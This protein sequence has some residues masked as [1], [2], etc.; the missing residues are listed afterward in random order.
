MAILIGHASLDEN[1]QIKKG[2]AGDQT[3]GEVCTRGWYDK[4]WGHLLRCKDSEIAERMAQAC[5]AACRN[6]N[7]GYDQGQRN[8]L[9]T[10][11]LKVGYD[12]S[13][14]KTPCECDCSSLMCICAIAAGIPASYFYINGNMRTTSS[15]KNAFVRTGLFDV[16]TDPNYLTKD[17]LLKRGDILTRPGSHTVMVLGNGS[18]VAPAQP[19]APKPAAPA[20]AP[21][22]NGQNMTY[23]GK[24]IGSATA[25]RKI[26][27]RAGSNK[28]T[29][30]YGI[31]GKGAKVEVLDILSNG[32]YK[33]VWP[34]CSAGYAFTSN[35]GGQYY[36]YSGS[37]PSKFRVRTT[38][39]SLRVRAA[40]TTDSA[41]VK[42]VR[43]GTEF[44][45]LEE[46]GI[47]LRVDKNQWISGKYAERI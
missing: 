28:E 44:E 47:W 34:G 1:G 46:K 37:Q 29:K 32:W 36:S 14:I 23:V 4:G 31:L 40:A 45:V 17:N 25:L 8:T 12:L 16:I 21:A 11:A 33:I 24:G 35:A 5:E 9:H 19:E 3:K 42:Y 27:V 39:S 18:S 15:M 38:A 13:K 30:S 43:K 22:T 7:I 20:P 2:A 41:T 26:H 6:D 10:E